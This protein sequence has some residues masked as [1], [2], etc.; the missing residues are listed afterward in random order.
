M[1]PPKGEGLGRKGWPRG[2]LRLGFGPSFNQQAWRR[3]IGHVL[4]QKSVR[5]FVAI[6][7]PW[8][9]LRTTESEVIEGKALSSKGPANPPDPVSHLEASAALQS[10]EVLVHLPKVILRIG[11]MII[12]AHNDPLAF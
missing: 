11:K 4:I 5:Q 9:A 1:F 3:C 2:T 6:Q 10:F 12:I 8:R 7:I